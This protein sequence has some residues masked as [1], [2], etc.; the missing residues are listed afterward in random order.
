MGTDWGFEGNMLGTQKK[1]VK[2]ILM[3]KVALADCDID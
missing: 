3:Q 2:K 1:I